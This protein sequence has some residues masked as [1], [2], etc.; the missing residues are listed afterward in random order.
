MAAGSG[1]RATAAHHHH[2]RS[3]PARAPTPL[4]HWRPLPPEQLPPSHQGTLRQ[5]KD[6]KISL[7]RRQPLR[8]S[9]L[10]STRQQSRGRQQ[11]QMSRSKIA[12]PGGGCGRSCWRRRRR[13]AKGTPQTSVSLPRRRRRPEAAARWGGNARRCGPPPRQDGNRSR[14]KL[15]RRPAVTRREVRGGPGWK[16]WRRRRRRQVRAVPSR[17]RP[18]A[19]KAWVQPSQRSAPWLR[20]SPTPRRRLRLRRWLLVSSP[21]IALLSGRRSP[22]AGRYQRFWRKQALNSC[23]VL[24]TFLFRM[25]LELFWRRRMIT[26][27]FFLCIGPVSPA[28]GRARRLPATVKTAIGPSTTTEDP[29]AAAATAAAA[30]TAPTAQDPGAPAP[31]DT[32]DVTRDK[33]QIASEQK[34][35]RPRSARPA[36]AATRRGRGRGAHQGTPL[37]QEEGLASAGDQAP[38]AAELEEAAAAKPIQTA[39]PTRS[40]TAA[41]AE[42]SVNGS[43]AAAVALKRGF[44]RAGTAQETA[45]AAGPESVAAAK[46]TAEGNAVLAKATKKPSRAGRGKKAA[47][48]VAQGPEEQ[49]SARAAAGEAA[50]VESEAAARGS[51][52]AGSKK[53]RKLTESQTAA[54]TL[55]QVGSD[56][57]HLV[58][59]SGGLYVVPWVLR[60]RILH[61]LIACLCRFD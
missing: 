51:G 44:Q 30:E 36:S 49:P 9:L 19:C 4:L 46:T 58:T 48:A 7:K 23:C 11:C 42:G 47:A 31:H 50:A 55:A 26:R 41:A 35:P 56:V 57:V 54:E 14:R 40:A 34:T 38:A 60:H 2:V 59:W 45:S 6:H 17:A 25:R 27:L 33:D 3:R 29:S 5:A 22:V 32:E 24:D 28:K 15:W 13:R 16:R 21:L 10:R 37:S 20:A 8:A 52:P 43:A 18:P 1:G 12:R 53:K 61:S 39:Q